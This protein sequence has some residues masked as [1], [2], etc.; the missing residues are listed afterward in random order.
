MEWKYTKDET[1]ITYETGDWD[2]KR[3]DKVVVIN[4]SGTA[5][6]ARL[7]EGFMDGSEYKDWIDSN[8]YMIYNIVKWFP[9]PT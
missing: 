6:I 1:P 2:G 3:S 4:E 9:L 7:Y 8:D 5:Y